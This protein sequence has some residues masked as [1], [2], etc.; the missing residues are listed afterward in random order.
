MCSIV[1]RDILDAAPEEIK[2]Q[3]EHDREVEKTY[4]ESIVYNND[5]AVGKELASM[6][7]GTGSSVNGTNM[8]EID[9]GV[10]V[11]DILLTT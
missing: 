1:S 10:S 7:H 4:I 2:V 8:M 9:R 5:V 3:A 6:N 11:V